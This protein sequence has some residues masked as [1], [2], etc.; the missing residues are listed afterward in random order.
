MERIHKEYGHYVEAKMLR[1]RY[2]L[3]QATSVY[4]KEKGRSDKVT[5]YLGWFTE[6]GVFIPAEHRDD[7]TKK[8][9]EMEKQE[10]ERLSALQDS[11]NESEMKREDEGIRKR[12]TERHERDILMTLSMDARKTIPELVKITGIK[13]TAVAYHL[14]NLERRY[15]MEY[16]LEIDIERF[17]YIDYVAFG[18][19]IDKPV[20]SII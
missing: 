3:F 4:N 14:R 5:K 20:V 13:E 9:N 15:D 2:R 11:Q 8:L 6:D 19:F 7:R 17:G 18:K 12:E 1:G 10:K 16:V